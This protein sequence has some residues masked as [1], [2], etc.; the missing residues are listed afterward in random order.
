MN[1]TLTFIAGTLLFLCANGSTENIRDKRS[2]PQFYSMVGYVTGRN[3]I[4]FSG[5]GN[6]CLVGAKGGAHP[7][8]GIDW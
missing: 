8:D 5:H 6:W 1:T 3:A 2:V 7:I 4:D